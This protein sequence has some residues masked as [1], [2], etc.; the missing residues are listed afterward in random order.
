MQL[1][2]LFGVVIVRGLETIAFAENGGILA[3]PNGIHFPIQVIIVEDVK[4]TK[5]TSAKATWFMILS[6]NLKLMV[7]LNFPSKHFKS[8]TE[9]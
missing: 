3:T 4:I 6:C 5:T 8:K 2:D 9:V 7:K 1:S